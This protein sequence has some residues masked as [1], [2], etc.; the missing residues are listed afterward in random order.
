MNKWFAS[1][2]LVTLCFSIAMVLAGCSDDEPRSTPSGESIPTVAPEPT[3][4]EAPDPTLTEAPDPT[5][6]VVSE[7]TSDA[8]PEEFTQWGRAPGVHADGPKIVSYVQREHVRISGSNEP[9]SCR[10]TAEI[11]HSAGTYGA[12]MDDRYSY[13]VYVNTPL[14]QSGNCPDS[15]GGI[16]T[17]SLT[18]EEAIDQSNDLLEWLVTERD[19][20]T[21]RE[22]GQLEED[23]DILD[24]ML[25]KANRE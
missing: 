24:E 5:L 22:N 25:R 10:Y 3:L 6:T 20:R 21:R 23:E 1:G 18:L 17:G 4:T 15:G 7:P 8:I 13:D 11:T 14:D 2:A 9:H 19:L 12:G 16:S